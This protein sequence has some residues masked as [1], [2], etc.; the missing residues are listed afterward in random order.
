MAKTIKPIPE[1]FRTITPHISV[2]GAAK[3]LDF[4]KQAFGAV[5]L[6]RMAGPDGRLMHAEVRI[7]DSILMLNDDFPE[8]AGSPIAE[9]RWPFNLHI[10][11]PDAD[12]AFKRATE[13]GCQVTM[14]LDNQF[15]G[16]RYGLVRDP[17]GFSWGIATHVEEPTAE[18]ME[19]RM[20]AMFGGAGK[21]A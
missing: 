8:Y 4:L 20:K 10:Y 12:A 17:F 19:A 15:W 7:G 16:D 1:G 21:G 3:Y 11:V 14:P 6:G 18:E 13:A 9:G 5:E 2:N